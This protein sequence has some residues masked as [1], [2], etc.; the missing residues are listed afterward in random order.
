[1]RSRA[2]QVNFLWM[3]TLKTKDAEQHSV[4][5]K[6]LEARGKHR[7]IVDLENVDV[8]TKPH[9]LP[10]HVTG[11]DTGKTLEPFGKVWDLT[12]GKCKEE[13]F[14]GIQ[15]T[16]RLVRLSTTEDVAPECLPHQ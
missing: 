11:K 7:V 15:S 4:A 16:T 13:G 1:M 5:A 12:R 14:T 2:Y 9:R 3:V 8:C 6:E 10:F